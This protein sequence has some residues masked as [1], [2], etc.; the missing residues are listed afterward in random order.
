MEETKRQ[1]FIRLAESRINNALKQIELLSNL[2]NSSVYEYS[3]EDVNQM[4]KSLKDAIANLEYSFK[5]SKKK[6]SFKDK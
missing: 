5:D 4:I 1:K 2:S 3:K 6:F